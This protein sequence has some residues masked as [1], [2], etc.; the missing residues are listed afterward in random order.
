MSLNYKEIALILSELPLTHSLIQKVHQIGYNGLLF[1]LYSPT[2]GFWELYVEIGTNFSRLHRLSSPPK[3]HKSKKTAKLQRFIQYLR[4][5]IEGSKIVECYQ[6]KNERIVVLKVAQK[7]TISHLVIRLFSASAANVIVCD[8]QMVIKELFY[9]RPKSGLIANSQLIIEEPKEI[10]EQKFQIRDYPKEVSF[11]EFIESSYKIGTSFDLSDLEKLVEEKEQNSLTKL[12][13]QLSI[14]A[15]NLEKSQNY[16]Q[17][18]EI[19]DLLSSNIHLLK[20]NIQWITLKNFST[21]NDITIQLDPLLKPSENIESYYTKYKK[22]K[23]AYERFASDISLIKE[24]TKE[25]QEYWTQLKSKIKTG[26]EKEKKE[27]LLHLQQANQLFKQTE[28][29]TIGLSFKSGEFTILV[30]RNADE[31][32]QLLRQAVKGNDWWLHLRDNPGSY[33]FIK[34]MRD[35]SIPLETILDAAALAMLYSKASKGSKA[36]LYYTQVKYLRRQKGGKK[37][38]VIPTQEKTIIGTLD[39]KRISR[40][41]LTKSQF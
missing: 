31:N 12:Y 34:T 13:K 1:E 9:R 3:E 23:T 35:K 10:D 36:D 26:S 19:G 14:V 6:I 28:T 17:Y 37:G 25:Q 30:G 39:E 20:N 40:L 24:K 2:E 5:H 32:D 7:E 38:A 15:N 11:N 33:V 16:P 21:D 8:E 18:K 41:F 22:G 4:A 27:I 29:K